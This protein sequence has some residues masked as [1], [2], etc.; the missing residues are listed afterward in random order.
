MTIRIAE[1]EDSSLI[2]NEFG[3]F[4]PDLNIKLFKPFRQSVQQT[5]GLST[6]RIVDDQHTRV[7]THCFTFFIMLHGF[8][9]QLQVT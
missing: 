5:N 8:I 1:M 7:C 4:H 9:N 3:Q 6:E 2:A